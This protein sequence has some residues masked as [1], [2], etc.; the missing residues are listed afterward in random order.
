MG[1]KPPPLKGA[2]Q[3]PPYLSAHV[4]CSQTVTHL[5][6][7]CAL[8]RCLDIKSVFVLTNRYRPTAAGTRLLTNNTTAM[9]CVG[10]ILSAVTESV[11]CSRSQTVTWVYINWWGI[12]CWYRPLCQEMILWRVQSNSVVI[13][14]SVNCAA[15]TADRYSCRR[16]KVSQ[17]LVTIGEKAH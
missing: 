11:N 3:P 10:L 6:N 7:C 15:Y 1:A 14:M 12:I 9:Q 13:A 17:I 5:N 8:C 2:Q 4:C 16:M